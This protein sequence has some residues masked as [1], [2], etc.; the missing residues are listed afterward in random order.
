MLNLIVESKLY[1]ILLVVLCSSNNIRLLIFPFV[2]SI[3][4]NVNKLNILF[5]ENTIVRRSMN[6]LPGLY[7]LL[8]K[9]VQYNHVANIQISPTVVAMMR[10]SM[11]L[12]IAMSRQQLLTT[13]RTHTTACKSS[14]HIVHMY[15]F[16][17]RILSPRKNKVVAHICFIL[18]SSDIK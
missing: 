3:N 11:L 10:K 4:F 2:T 14:W 13:I 7:Y 8:R 5:L 1:D 17:L 16:A 15:H 18:S 9:L 12:N 6:L